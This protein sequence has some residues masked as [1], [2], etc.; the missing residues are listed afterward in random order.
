V[1]TFFFLFRE[2]L[3]AIQARS[4]AV[5]ATVILLIFVCLA[6]F[7]TLLLVGG[8]AAGDTGGLG[9]DEIVVHLSPRLSAEAVDDLYARI[10]MRS[11]VAAIAFR[12]AEEVRPG[13]TGGRFFVRATTADA[14][15]N[16]RGE[17]ESTDGVTEIESGDGAEIEGGF[18]LPPSAR[19][20]LLLALVLSVVASLVLGRVG[21][22]A[23]LG[24]FRVEIRIM[25][26]SG[27]SERTIVPPVVG[28]GTLIGLLAGLL[29][30]A[31]IYLG[32][33]AVGEGAT[34]VPKLADGGL[35]LGVTFAGLI[36]GLLLGTFVG[37]FG[38]SVLASREFSPLP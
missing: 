20:A 23:L 19:L 31:G 2:L 30:I 27:T 8:A 26:V 38:A 5:F 36:L 14:L 17:L 29:L 16:V 15:V 28:L 37:L 3:G 13:S 9:P 18:T 7:A 25:R 4:A 11:D 21:F 12:F 32:Q 10:R 1:S 24:A 34:V 6:S 35:V 33:Y 22:R